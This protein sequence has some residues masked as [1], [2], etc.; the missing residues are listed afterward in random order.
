MPQAI[1]W[2]LATPK[3]S[4]FLP[5]SS[6]IGPPRV[7]SPGSLPSAM[8]TAIDVRRDRRCARRCAASARSSSMPTASSSLPGRAAPGVGRGGRASSRRAGSRSASSPTSRRPIATTLARW[9]GKARAARRRRTGS[10]PRPRR[11]PP[12]RRGRHPASRC[13]CWPRPMRAASSP[14]S[15]CSTPD[16]ADALPA[17]PVAAVVIGD[18][19]DD[20]S[21]RNLDIAFRQLRG[22]AEFVAMHR[23]PW[24]LTPEGSRS[25]PAPFVAGLEFATGAARRI[26][27]KPSPVVFRQARRRACAAELG[28]RPAAVATF[29]MVGDDSGA[30][31]AA[32]QRVGLRGVLVLTGKHGPA[33]VERGRPPERGGRG[34]DAIAAVAGRRR[35]RA[36]L[37]ATLPD[38]ATTDP[39][40]GPTHH[41]RPTPS[42]ASRSPT[43]RCAPTTRSCTRSSRTA[44]DARRASL[45]GAPPELRRR[46]PGA[47]ATARSRPARRSIATSSSARSR[48]GTAADVDDAVAAARAAQPAWAA[49]PW[50]RAPRDP[51][52][53]P[54]SSSASA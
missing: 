10:S 1:E 25:T 23:N 30:D 53:G 5:S 52:A 37:T 3:M 43:R 50:Q 54:P 36:R 34:P 40:R 27:G 13:S 16:E 17:E 8:T 20:L 22:G 35:R 45:G 33:D 48:R 29:A 6:P 9:F 31:V 15:S 26:L 28:E 49:T 19:G 12:T 41:D 7:P 21:Y 24:W 47:T 42:R 39:P 38:R 14:A 2:S 18:A 11:Q 32:A 4:A 51:R 46:R 44:V